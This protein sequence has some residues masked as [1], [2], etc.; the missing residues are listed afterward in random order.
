M[1][2][3]TF[4]LSFYIVSICFIL[5][6]ICFN[7]RPHTV[8]TP[9]PCVLCYVHTCC[10]TTFVYVLHSVPMC[11]TIHTSPLIDASYATRCSHHPMTACL[12]VFPVTP[13]HFHMLEDPLLHLL[14]F[15]Q[16]L[17]EAG[18]VSRDASE[19]CA[20]FPTYSFLRLPNHGILHHALTPSPLLRPQCIRA[21]I[22]YI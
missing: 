10:D 18:C 1:S 8:F 11:R 17:R 13:V 3:A 2:Y 21:H 19:P 12:A 14:L 5:H 16:Q 15:C 9:F 20:W 7:L 4:Q 22:V 6:P